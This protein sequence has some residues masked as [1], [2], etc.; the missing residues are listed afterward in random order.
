ME[1]FKF[2]PP[3]VPTFSRKLEASIVS[4]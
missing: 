1:I 3:K 2:S 4:W